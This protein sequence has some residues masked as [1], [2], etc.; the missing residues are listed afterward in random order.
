MHHLFLEFLR[1]VFDQLILVLFTDFMRCKPFGTVGTE[2][3][4]I[5]DP[6]YSL[7]FVK[8]ILIA[9]PVARNA[10]CANFFFHDI[11]YFKVLTSIRMTILPKLRIIF[12]KKPFLS[13]FWRDHEKM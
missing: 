13:L 11:L 2:A 4:V 7:I 12:Y 3:V 5:I 1:T 6:F 8:C 10:D 9:E